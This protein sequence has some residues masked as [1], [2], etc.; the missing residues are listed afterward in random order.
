MIQQI[1]KKT[2]TDFDG[3]LIAESIIPTFD[4]HLFCSLSLAAHTIDHESQNCLKPSHDQHHL[5]LR[6]TIN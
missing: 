1:G 5:A 3:K 2:L 4:L 6:Y